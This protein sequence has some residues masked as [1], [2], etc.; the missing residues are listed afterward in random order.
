MLIR[1]FRSSIDEQSKRELA[2]QILEVDIAN[3]AELERRIGGY[4]NKT[5]APQVPP[6]YRT[7]SELVGD[8]ITQEKNAI[9]TMTTLGFEYRD[10]AILTKWLSDKGK[11][12]QFNGSA[13]FIKTDLLKKYNPSIMDVSFLKGYLE[14]YFENLEVN[15]GHKFG[16]DKI[17]LA[18]IA[19]LK[20]YVPLVSD[21]AALNGAINAGLADSGDRLIILKEILVRFA[22]VIP[23]GE[24]IEQLQ[25]LSPNEQGAAL[26]QIARAI[27]RNAIPSHTEIGQMIKKYDKMGTDMVGQAGQIVEADKLLARLGQMSAENLETFKKAYTEIKKDI[28]ATADQVQGNLQSIVNVKIGDDAGAIKGVLDFDTDSDSKKIQIGN[29]I[30]RANTRAKIE[31]LTAQLI[32]KLNGF[33]AAAQMEGLIDGNGDIIGGLHLLA[34]RGAYLG[35]LYDVA[36]NL[37]DWSNEEKNYGDKGKIVA[38]RYSLGAHANYEDPDDAKIGFGMKKD[39]AYEKAVKGIPKKQIK[40]VAKY[41]HEHFVDDENFLKKIAKGKKAESDSDSEMEGKIMKDLHRHKKKTEPLE[42]KVLG[43]GY[44]HKRIP[45]KKIIGSGVQLEE[46]PTYRTFGKFVMHIPFL[47]NDNVLN[48]KYPSLG[49]IPSIKP[50]TISDDYKEFIIEVMN[51]GKVNDKQYSYLP[52]HEQKHFER[53]TKG[54]GLI[55]KFNLK[56][57]GDDDEK[58]DVDRFNLL[59]GNYLAGNNSD[60]LIKELRGLVV[61]FMSENRIQRGEGMDLL[62]ELSVI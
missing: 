9:E 15:F 25:A 26:Q 40:N 52:Q 8:V 18:S 19:Q 39:K 57:T 5:T 41:I 61:K 30:E 50:T 29:I 49:S 3:E 54:A 14:K 13:P 11:L 55:E 48:L 51:S 16:M 45:V 7:K 38:A 1:N 17:Q 22:N 60:S 27:E 23:T 34:D 46:K 31:D 20:A 58:K 32:N 6:Q 28:T 53:I 62:M 33:E 47:M 24:V 37:I 42:K 10:A 21:I 4:Q 56:R 35:T 36:V 59:R 43:E 2:K 44:I 12:I